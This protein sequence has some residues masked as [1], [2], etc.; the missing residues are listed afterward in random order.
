MLG[1]FFYSAHRVFAQTDQ[2]ALKLQDANN[3][4]GQAFNSVS[5]VEKA[6]GNVT[7]LL[8]KLNTAATNLANAQNAVNS[9]STA[10]ITSDL[11]NVRQIANQ[12]NDEALNLRNVSLVD[13]QISLWLTLI[14]S[15]AG[16]VVFCVSLFVVWRRFKRAYIKKLLSKK[17]E[18]VENAP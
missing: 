8:A 15:V 2:I 18:V 9:G 12:V 4:V 6:G 13:S 17:P 14:F 7:Q 1:S 10:N 11:E 5:E 16:A 3:A